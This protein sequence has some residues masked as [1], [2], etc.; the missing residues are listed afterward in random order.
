M[1]K[2]PLFVIM[3]RRD[4]SDPVE[5]TWLSS[6]HHTWAEAKS[7]MYRNRPPNGANPYF[8]QELKPAEGDPF[9]GRKH[10]AKN[11]KPFGRGDR[12]SGR[13]RFL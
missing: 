2:L 8:I 6:R 7:E 10:R 11:V 4:G 5:A 13:T 12:G 9:F 3:M 1:K